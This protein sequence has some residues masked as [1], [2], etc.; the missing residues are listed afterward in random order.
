MSLLQT[1]SFEF[2]PQL[3]ALSRTPKISSLHCLSSCCSDYY[4]SCTS[5]KMNP[6]AVFKPTKTV[7]V[8][9]QFALRVCIWFDK[10]DSNFA[11]TDKKRAQ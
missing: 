11:L 8:T 7:H 1:D 6:T 2:K 10:P 4:V 9:I 5:R 3:T